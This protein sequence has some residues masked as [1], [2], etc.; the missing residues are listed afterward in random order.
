MSKT[1]TTSQTATVTGDGLS[2]TE[3]PN[4]VTNNSAQP[5]GSI[6]C[7]TGANTVTVPGGVMG[8]MLVPPP[9]N[10]LTIMLKGVT[11]DTGVALSKVNPTTLMFDLSPP[12]SFVLTVGSGTVTIGLVWL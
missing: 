7:S 10:A 11:G 12:A 9:T 5:P 1:A 2:Y 6:A 3:G 8:V 4:A